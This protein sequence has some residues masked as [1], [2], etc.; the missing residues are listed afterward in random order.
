MSSA[1]ELTINGD[2]PLALE[3]TS[4]RVAVARFQVHTP[5]A[6]IPILQCS[7]S[8][9]NLLQHE[10]HAGALKL[11]RH[12]F[13][14]NLALERAQTLE[15][16]NAAI[17]DELAALRA[18]PDVTPH[19]ATLQ[20]SDLTL[21]LRRLS[22]KLTHTEKTLLTRNTEC[23]NA[24]SDVARSKRETEGAY[25]L[26]ARARAHTEESRAHERE[27]TRRVRAVE[28]ER[29][30]TDR[31]VKEYAT[32][33]RNLERKNSLSSPPPSSSNGHS[34]TSS[35]GA[36]AT[37]LEGGRS[38][39]NKLFEEFSTESER[40]HAEL[41]HFHTEFERVD[42]ALEAERKAAGFERAEL[43]RAQTELEKLR[44]DDTTAAKMVSRYM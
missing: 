26:A 15:R 8:C 14:A 29:D 25:A 38:G 1:T 20:A 31:V 30:M 43:A 4:L 27:L 6:P 44:A 37:D 35:A 24:L 34:R 16:E 39:M 32:L 13:E 21:A 5:Y 2:H 3:L 33:V 12:S 10:A 28:E 11:Q 40:L 23:T 22:D 18:H 19:P 41:A 9:P 17:R 36:L 7:S 42:R